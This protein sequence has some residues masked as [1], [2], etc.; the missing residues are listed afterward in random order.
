MS[1]ND[2]IDIISGS[3]SI[4]D[5]CFLAKSEESDGLVEEQELLKLMMKK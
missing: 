4:N 3:S 5:Q 2:I 1:S